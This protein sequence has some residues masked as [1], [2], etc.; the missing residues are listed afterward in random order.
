MQPPSGYLLPRLS[1]GGHVG[2]V[3]SAGAVGAGGPAGLE[4]R[5]SSGSGYISGRGSPV[6]FLGQAQPQQPALQATRIWLQ[7]RRV[8]HMVL[9][10]PSMAAQ[11]VHF[12]W[13]AQREGPS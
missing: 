12:G 5:G 3:G 1:Q 13:E 6:P 9:W 2:R 8:Q 4:T 10:H 7:V 11:H